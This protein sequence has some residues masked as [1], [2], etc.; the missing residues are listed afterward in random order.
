MVSALNR[1]LQQ[2]GTKDCQLFFKMNSKRVQVQL[3][4]LQM[5]FMMTNCQGICHCQ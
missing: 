5:W 3:F 2:K 1:I 4:L